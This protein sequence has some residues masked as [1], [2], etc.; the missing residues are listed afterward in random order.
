M[1]MIKEHKGDRCVIRESH[2]GHTLDYINRLFAEARKDFPYL[3]AKDIEIVVYGGDR[4]KRMM[5]IEF[6]APDVSF[7]P[8]DYVTVAELELTLS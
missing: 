3:Q 5:G 4:I 1:M 7:V 2:Y 8:S 6:N